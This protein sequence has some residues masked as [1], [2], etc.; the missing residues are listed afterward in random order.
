MLTLESVAAPGLEEQDPELQEEPEPAAQE[1]PAVPE[2]SEP[3]VP[4][5]SQEE[6]EIAKPAPK[7]R[8]IPKVEPATPRQLLPRLLRKQQFA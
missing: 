8:G 1:E 7:R 5:E 3:A 6:P 4:E 2:E